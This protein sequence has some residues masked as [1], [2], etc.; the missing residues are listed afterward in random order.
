M[1]DLEHLR[2]GKE[3]LNAPLST[4]AALLE[5]KTLFSRSLKFQKSTPTIPRDPK[6]WGIARQIPVQPP[7]PVV[8]LMGAHILLSPPFVYFVTNPT[9]L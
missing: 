1:E 2:R 9:S 3:G 7:P 5:G 8:T 6:I 4:Y